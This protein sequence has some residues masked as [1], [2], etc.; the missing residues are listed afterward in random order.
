MYPRCP[1]S[2]SA[3]P[4][5]SIAG[6]YAG[7]CRNS[8]S[9]VAWGGVPAGYPSAGWGAP[10][11]PTLFG[12]WLAKLSI[13]RCADP[14]E[15][16]SDTWSEKNVQNEVQAPHTVTYGPRYLIIGLSVSTVSVRA[17]SATFVPG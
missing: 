11:W 14:S 12:W 9:L 13:A 7:P 17:F 8:A 10:C 6:L 15:V 16:C 1:V 4:F 5:E 2:Q 3:L